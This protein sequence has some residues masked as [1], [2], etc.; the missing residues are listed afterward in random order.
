MSLDTYFSNAS[1]CRLGYSVPALMAM[2]SMEMPM[3]VLNLEEKLLRH[4]C[5]L[6]VKLNNVNRYIERNV[7]YNLITM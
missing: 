5:Y 3:R 2:S 7:S 1:E 6:K 4:S